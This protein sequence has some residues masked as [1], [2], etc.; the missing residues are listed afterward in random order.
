M[1]SL[2]TYLEWLRAHG[3]DP[4]DAT[5]ADY[6]R[7]REE[8]GLPALEPGEDWWADVGD[9]I[10]D[11]LG[12]AAEV[13]GEAVTAV[14]GLVGAGVGAVVE[15]LFEKAKPFLVFSAAALAIVAVISLAR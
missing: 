2:V 11:P 10:L 3:I 6:A 9:A 1:G 14:G 5:D 8:T 15:P 7:W 12:T 13:A 4:A